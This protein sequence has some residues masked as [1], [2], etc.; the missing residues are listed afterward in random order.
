[1]SNPWDIPPL[2]TQGDREE[3]ITYAGVGRV[4][5]RWEG[6][7]LYLGQ[8]YSFCVGRPNKLPAIR[9]YGEG[10]TFQGRITRLQDAAAG[11]F[12]GH[13]DQSL[14]ADFDRII[15]YVRNYAERRHEVAHGTVR[16]FHW[17]FPDPTVPEPDTPQFCLVPPYYKGN[18]F[19]PDNAPSYAYTRKELEALEVALV[20]LLSPLS[21]M[22]HRLENKAESRQSPSE[23]SHSRDRAG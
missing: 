18:K 17:E 13:P 6:V 10:S 23:P 12:C 5:T 16:P 3:D 9:S 19:A 14:E 4:L 15:A 1:M 2:P 8:L 21:E 22:M 20:G 11:F 7:E